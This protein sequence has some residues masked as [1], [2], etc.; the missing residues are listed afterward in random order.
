MQLA[1]SLNIVLLDAGR[2]F[3]NGHTLPLGR[4]RETPSSLQAADIVMITRCD[5]DLEYSNLTGTIAGR[6]PRIKV[7]V[8]RMKAK[9]LV[10]LS[11]G[12]SGSVRS[13][14]GKR[15][16]A[17]CGIGNPLSFF[18]AA[19]RL[20]YKLV[21]ERTFRDHHRY[22]ARDIV[23]LR[24]HAIRKHA[25]VFLITEKDATNLT[26]PGQLELPVFALQIDLEVDR[27]EE[28]LQLVMSA[29]ADQ[30]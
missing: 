12:R 9:G 14:V 16:A 6:N 11:S 29:R 23:G 7:F 28:L 4:L 20:G 25:D 17:F 24:R 26:D 27:A 8:S 10:D 3:G 5:R 19:R 2:P 18:S 13:L 30:G 22:T 1:R 15:V 21:L